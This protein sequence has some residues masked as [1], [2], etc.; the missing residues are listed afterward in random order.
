MTAI[1]SCADKAA[2]IAAF[3]VNGKASLPSTFMR[4]MVTKGYLPYAC[5]FS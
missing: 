3:L 5:G 2:I 1:P 4:R